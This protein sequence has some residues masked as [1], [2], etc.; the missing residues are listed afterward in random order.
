MMTAPKTKKAIATPASHARIEPTARPG[1]PSSRIAI[2]RLLSLEAPGR[3][4]GAGR[5][6]LGREEARF[7][8]EVHVQLLGLRDP[9]GVVLADHR[10]LVE[11]AVL[12]ELLPLGR[13]AHLLE[14]IR[15]ELHLVG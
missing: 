15:V 5:R 6:L 3:R 9:L 11:G 14:E 1:C 13:L 7:L 12:H 10:G 2:P 4:P 8:H